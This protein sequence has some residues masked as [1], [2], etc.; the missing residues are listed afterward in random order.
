MYDF[1]EQDFPIVSQLIVYRC[2]GM[3]SSSGTWDDQSPWVSHVQ[4]QANS[5]VY[6]TEPYK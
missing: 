6:I 3:L 1:S 4:L 2:A 5:F